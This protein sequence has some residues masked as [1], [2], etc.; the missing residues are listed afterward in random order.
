MCKHIRR[1]EIS[2]FGHSPLRG[3]E[4]RLLISH[5]SPETPR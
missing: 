3:D 5:R 2:T 4:Q 1:R